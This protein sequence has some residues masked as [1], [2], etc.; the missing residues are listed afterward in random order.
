MHR[1][2]VQR[3][4]AD[5]TAG[6][7]FVHEDG[8]L[9][10]RA[11]AH[12]H[13]RWFRCLVRH[14]VLRRVRGERS[15]KPSAGSGS[16]LTPSVGSATSGP[17]ERPWAR[18]IRPVGGPSGIPR[19]ATKPSHQEGLR[20]LA[21]LRR[22]ASSTCASPAGCRRER[23]RAAS[24]TP[25]C[26]ISTASYRSPAPRT[27][28]PRSTS[29]SV[30]AACEPP[31]HGT[32]RPASGHILPRGPVLAGVGSGPLVPCTNSSERRFIPPRPARGPSGVHG[33]VRSGGDIG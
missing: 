9:A 13:R 19:D 27:R 1:R 8:P 18:A 12:T 32:C 30:E 28:G 24:S 11:S 22:R 31:P 21:G 20:P 3:T 29:C 26:C 2:S 16:P 4:R 25:T 15:L 10:V 14:G 5:R 23:V 7:F 17:L 6:G 33:T